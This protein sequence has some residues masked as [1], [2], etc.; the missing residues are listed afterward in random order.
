MASKKYLFLAGIFCL[1]ASTSGFSQRV[2]ASYDVKDS[3]VIRSKDM[4]Q[5][6]EFLNGTQN[7]PAKPRNQLEIGI[8]AG[9]FTCSG[10]VPAT[11]WSPGF[12]VPVRKTFGYIFS[13]R[14]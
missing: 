7:F 1:L 8:K 3:S 14:F 11:T 13:A 5:H 4:A 9:L 12:G 6:S 2:G 10:D